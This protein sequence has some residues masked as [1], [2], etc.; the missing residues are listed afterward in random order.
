MRGLVRGISTMD[1]D[2]VRKAVRQESRVHG[3]TATTVHRNRVTRQR[4]EFLV[5]HQAAL[6]AQH[7]TAVAE[8]EAEIA[9]R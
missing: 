6:A 2:K 1:A 7:E 9:R 3:A 4:E 5:A 8:H